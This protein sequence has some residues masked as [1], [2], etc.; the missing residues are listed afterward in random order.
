MPAGQRAGSLVAGALALCAVLAVPAS[1]PASER[2]A[3][4]P[5][6]AETVGRAMAD[7][8]IPGIAVAVVQPGRDPTLV[9]YGV[10]QWNR[11]P[12]VTPQTLFGIASITKTFVA[13]GIALLAQRGALDFDDPVAKHL[14]EF[15][16]ADPWISREL[17]LRDLLAHRSGIASHGD[18]LEEVPG[19][20]EEELV[21]RLAHHGQSMPLRAGAQYSSYGYVVLARVIE[22]VAGQPWERFLREQLWGPL[23]M[24]HARAR[25][26][27]FVPAANVLPSGD[28]WSDRVPTGLDAVAA[29]TDVAAPHVQWEAFYRGTIVYDRRELANRTVH[30]H[31]TA[32]D[33]GQSAFASVEDMA[34]WAQLLLQHEGAGGVLDPQ[35]VRAMRR[36]TSVRRGDWPLNWAEIAADP[37]G[38][39]RQVGFGLGLEIYSYRGRSLFGHSGGE[40]G[41]AS[42]MV[43]DPDTGL[44]VVVLANNLT[45]TFGA[46]HALV[47]M[48]LDWH[49]GLAPIDW[50]RHYLE[51][52]A[53]EHAENLGQLA[54]LRKARPAGTRPSLPLAAYA[55]EYASPLGGHLRIEVRGG[56]LVATTGPSYEIELE[57]WAH[58]VF[59]G[60]VVSPLRLGVFVSF[61]VDRLGAV[62]ALRLE[63]LEIPETN[64][65]FER[66]EPREAGA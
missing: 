52:G 61:E 60:T 7:W 26:D 15:R 49:Y 11:E 14:P 43:L 54:E 42:L 65:R 39:L 63:Y 33:P 53:R 44:G 51:R 19:L 27:E 32:I 57:H 13:G 16:V 64:L 5:D 10:R 34:R 55:G 59:A 8:S 30:F 47:Q 62:P 50:S 17:T 4:P 1:A 29:D 22:R 21:A 9:A 25:S 66:I 6:F 56:R 36:L 18:F 24:R 46:A 48:L 37:H 41:Y 45:R 20:S 23:G 38:G 31:R 40:L 12:P 35:T 28:G 58:E 2:P 3:L